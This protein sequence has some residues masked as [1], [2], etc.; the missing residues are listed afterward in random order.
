MYL[1][2]QNNNQHHL[3]NRNENSKKVI[4]YSSEVVIMIAD[5]RR[6]SISIKVPTIAEGAAPIVQ[7]AM[8][9]NEGPTGSFLSDYGVTSR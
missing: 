9:G 1:I 6:T 3:K 7:Y 4:K 8:I 5:K 2:S